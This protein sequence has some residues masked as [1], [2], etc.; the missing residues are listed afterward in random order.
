M[1]L[2]AYINTQGNT[3]VN[4]F[5][6]T[7]VAAQMPEAFDVIENFIRTTSPVHIL[8]IGTATGGLT[9]FINYVGK[10][11]NDAFKMISVDIYEQP[12]YSV[13]REEGVTVL[14]EN[15]FD[16]NNNTIINKEV[17]TM[18]LDNT[19]KIIFCDG[20]NKI[21]EFNLLAQYLRP[22][23]FILAHDYVENR[24]TFASSFNGVRWNWMEISDADI[25]D[26]CATYNLVDYNRPVFSNVVWT[27]KEKI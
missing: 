12:Q 24:D 7:F 26:T 9:S 20:G 3:T 2:E 8:E 13:L 5:G 4:K 27:C 18:L 17:R 14:V 23:D 6:K 11:S 25:L 22:H 15:I 1:D 19:R 10:E 21:K 16:W